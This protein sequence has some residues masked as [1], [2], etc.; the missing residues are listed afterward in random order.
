[1]YSAALLT[2]SVIDL[3]HRI[4]PDEISLS[5]IVVGLALAALTPLRPFLDALAGALIGV[6]YGEPFYSTAP[7]A[8][9]DP[10]KAFIKEIK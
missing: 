8:I 2:V 1:M 3:D 9:E 5:G 10:I 6:K 4:I 7:P